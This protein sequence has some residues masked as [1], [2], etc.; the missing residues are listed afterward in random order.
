M[1]LNPSICSMY[2]WLGHQLCVLGDSSL[3]LMCGSWTHARAFHNAQMIQMMGPPAWVGFWCFLGSFSKISIIFCKYFVHA[4]VVEGA[5]WQCQFEDSRSKWSPSL[6]CHAQRWTC[7]LGNAL[8]FSVEF[9]EASSGKTWDWYF[10]F[11]HGSMTM[12]S[13]CNQ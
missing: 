4:C 5:W 9:S 2:D 6:L 12:L 10:V 1:S 8:I 3:Q 11:Y 7:Y 13:Y